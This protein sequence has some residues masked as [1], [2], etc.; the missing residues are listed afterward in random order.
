MNSHP[1]ATVVTAALAV[2]LV[3][4][5]APPPAPAADAPVPAATQIP[6]DVAA[7]LEAFRR[8]PWGDQ[9]KPS[10]P[11]PAPES[12]KTRCAAE[13][14]LA[15]IDAKD[16]AG[17]LPLLADPDRFVRAIAARAAGIAQPA[18][19][20]KAL[21]AALAAEKD[22]LVRLALVE[23][24][25]RS[26][27][28]GAVEAVEA[29]QQAGGD[30][31]LSFYVGLARRQLKGGAWDVASIRGENSEARGAAV[32]SAQVGKPAP[33]IAL[34]SSAGPV[35]LSTLKGRIVVLWF[36]HGDRGPGADMKA[37]QRLAGEEEK[38]GRW[39]VTVVVVDPHEKERTK[40]W[41]DRLKLPFT[42]ASDPAGRAAATYGVARQLFLGGE[43]LPS[44][45]C[46]LIDVRGK[47]VWKK[48]GT[49]AEEQ[50]S[51]GELLP[52]LDEMSQGI[53]I[54]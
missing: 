49:K 15:G 54:R 35:N 20:S 39:K 40:A 19:A 45:A 48:I 22:K 33:E 2:A 29:Q 1:R 51:L 47:L 38:L 25:G 21:V 11:E 12:W 31:D 42:V 52:L 44:P 18:G 43:W 53:E 16:A 37:L 24:V 34:P 23:A 27:G 8:V 4:A 7:K 9:L 32:A 14:A 10:R 41:A 3:F 28:D 50:A 5:V 46:F 13:W 26:G 30:P 17:I 36:A 6:A